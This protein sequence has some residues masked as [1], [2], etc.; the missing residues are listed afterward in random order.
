MEEKDRWLEVS[1][2]GMEAKP[3]DR[4]EL[5]AEDCTAWENCCKQLYI[6][7]YVKIQLKHMDSEIS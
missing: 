2:M 7:R 4:P 5:E 3:M 6:V 1:E